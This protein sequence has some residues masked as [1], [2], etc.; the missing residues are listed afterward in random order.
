MPMSLW[1][2]GSR[3]GGTK[4]QATKKNL[5]AEV[6]HFDLGGSWS[7]HQHRR[8]SA[9]RALVHKFKPNLLVAST[10][11]TLG[12]GP[13]NR[14]RQQVHESFCQQLCQEQVEGGR[15]FDWRPSGQQLHASGLAA[16]VWT[17][18]E[19]PVMTVPGKEH[20]LITNDVGIL[21]AN[22]SGGSWVEAVIGHYGPTREA[23]R[24]HH[25]HNEGEAEED[26]EANLDMEEIGDWW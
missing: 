22:V 8:R 11:A 21:C 16:A 15:E 5:K 12:D 19:H 7:P 13:R 14:A 6:V 9:L 3:L 2:G 4:P 10:P 20:N 25:Y 26:D 17:E 18:T 1:E 23:E 24:H